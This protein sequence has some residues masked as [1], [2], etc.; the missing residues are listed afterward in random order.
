MNTVN[1]D[2]IVGTM[3]YTVGGLCVLF[4]WLLF[5]DF[6]IA[7]R[8]RAASPSVLE[9]LRQHHASDTTMSVLLGVFPQILG[10]ILGPVISYKSDRFRSRWGRRIPFLAAPTP[11]GAMAMIG[12]GYCPWLGMHLHRFLG[13]ASPGVD[14]CVLA[15]FCLFWTAFESVVIV[16]GSIF[17]GLIND[18]VP[19]G[20]LGRFYAAF[21]IVSLGA[22]I[23]FNYWIFQLTETHLP[24]IFIGVGIFFG[25]GFTMMCLMVKEGNYPPPR[26]EE[27]EGGHP[28]GFKANIKTY[29]VECFSHRYYLWIFAAMVVAALAFGPFNAFAQWYADSLGMP[30]ATLGKLTAL[31]YGISIFLAFFIG[32]L[33]DR[34]SSLKMGIILMGVF[35]VTALLGFA[36]IGGPTSFG[37]VYVLHTVMSGAYF[38][39]T[40]SLAM[41]LY[42]RL[43]FTQFASA[44]GLLGSVVWIVVNLTQG[45]LLDLSG[46]NYRLTLLA[47][48]IFAAAALGLLLKVA[49]NYAN[50][51]G[52][53]PPAYLPEGN[54]HTP[55]S[56]T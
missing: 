12:L 18:V 44:G 25:V 51:Q 10:M 50:L 36:L 9:L 26:Q 3:T 37:I 11:I 35:M 19:H 49:R 21:R 27:T 23:F 32:W 8:E 14:F 20:L 55:Q 52:G 40:A 43:R 54:P 47:A 16:T 15:F 30:K 38:T 39:A 2:R 34:F 1:H 24:Q 31:S 13:S 29:F 56:T 7:L 22:G 5:G 4:F 28:H 46:H 42:P 6:A 33:V 41:V 17:G 48:G 53:V 45:I